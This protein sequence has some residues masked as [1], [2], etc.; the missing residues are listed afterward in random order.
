MNVQQVKDMGRDAL[1]HIPSKTSNF[2]LNAT[3]DGATI[4]ITYKDEDGKQTTITT[5]IPYEEES[6][7]VEL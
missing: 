7:T 5:Q 2:Q 3:D 4:K 6:E 1:K